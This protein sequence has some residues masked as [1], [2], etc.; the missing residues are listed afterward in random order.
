MARLHS[1]A[2][3]Q[4]SAAVK[5]TREIGMPQSVRLL[6]LWVVLSNSRLD[7]T[8]RRE[9]VALSDTADNPV[10]VRLT[11]RWEAALAALLHV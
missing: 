10:K 4:S 7:A 2:S 1:G 3:C 6:R 9:S 11:S 8:V 5:L